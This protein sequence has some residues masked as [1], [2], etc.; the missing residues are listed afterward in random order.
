M[1][2]LMVCKGLFLKKVPGF[3]RKH[4][5]SIKRPLCTLLSAGSALVAGFSASAAP[6]AET[7]E[8]HEARLK[9]FKEARFGMFIHW[10]VYA[11]PAGVWQGRDIPGIGEWIL[12][13]GKIPIATYRDFAKD[14]TAANYDP[15]AWADL[16]KEA[17]MKYVVI[18]SKH[19]DGFALYD[20]AVSDWDAVNASG[21]KRDLLEPL[22]KAVRGNGL[23][24]GLYYSQA[25]D[26][27][28]PGG[29]I[30]GT[31]TS[32]PGWDPAQTGDF[33]TYIQT[34][35][36]PQ[37]QEIL[38]RFKP[39]I[40]WWD[41]PVN[42][43][44]ELAKPLN[45]LLPQVPGIISN[46]RLGGGY[47]GDTKTPEQ[48][49]PPRGYPGEMFEVCMTMNETW[50]FK[51]NDHQ[52]KSVTQILHNLTD[53]ASKGGNFLLNVGPTADG[54]IP[55]E[56]VERLKSVGQWMKANGE[57]IYGTEASPFPRRLPWGRVTRKTAGG[58]TTL[59]L[60][61]WDWPADGK[62]LL[63]TL[64]ETPV[65]GR[66]LTNGLE[67][68]TSVSGDGLVLDLP[69]KA[70]DPIVSVAVLEFDRPLTITQQPFITAGAD[71]KIHLNALDADLHGGY[72]GT[73]KVEGKGDAAYL[74][75]WLDPKWRVEY[76]VSTPT[77]GTW[78]VEAEVIAPAA[79]GL[80]VKSGKT[81]TKVEVAATGDDTTYQ[82]VSLGNI[83]LPAGPAAFELKAE[84]AGWSP[85]QIRKV[86]LKP[87]K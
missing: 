21:A 68:Q 13:S 24:F 15:Q 57:A 56:S 65:S 25:Q 35:A 27:I 20:S 14:F 12:K 58:K 45:D 52:W 43:T 9:W 70:T 73:I 36:V 72:T 4:A 48:H 41:T 11:V 83:A 37:T 50:G 6:S 85:I 23:K 31:K 78:Q 59:Y 26:W 86:T 82:T 1:D 61:I 76:V 79:V 2:P 18:T 74:T 19:H 29:A 66:V 60:H 7:P 63:P 51:K 16:A 34:I 3:G 69:G 87:A 10:G 28:H 77:A 40:L 42:M 53:I 39:D 30:M 81:E 5:M 47:E 71:G 54:V 17:G 44:P 22:A 84:P 64:K 33:A 67:I 46:N 55:P 8:Q 75:H 62:L 80:L 32:Q 49:I 38:S